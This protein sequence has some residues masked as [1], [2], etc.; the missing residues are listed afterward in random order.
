MYIMEKSKVTGA[1]LVVGECYVYKGKNMGKFISFEL[2]GRA[3]DPDEKY[4]FENGIIDDGR[5]HQREMEFTPIQCS[6]GGA[7]RKRVTR[8]RSAT[9]QKSRRTRKTRGNK[10]HKR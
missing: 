10:K 6:G 2:T 7:R 9:T 5:F 4:T 1:E 3:Y 8:K